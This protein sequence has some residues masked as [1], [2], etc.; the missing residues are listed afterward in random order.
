MIYLLSD[1]A[2]A[3]APSWIKCGS[4]DKECLVET[5]EYY[6]TIYGLDENK[7]LETIRNES[8]F[9]TIPDGY[10]DN[11]LAFGVAQYHWETFFRHS[12][13]CKFN[14]EEV[15]YYDPILQIKTMACAFS[16]RHEQEWTAYR[17]LFGQTNPLK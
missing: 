12:R 3:Q 5:A 13:E 16:N 17:I 11:G 6:A 2:E 1:S 15:D 8:G 14:H 10:N 4:I 9:A 7:L